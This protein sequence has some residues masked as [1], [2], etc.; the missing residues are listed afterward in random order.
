MFPL[1][2]PGATFHDHHHR[3]PEEM[4]GAMVHMQNLPQEDRLALGLLSGTIRTDHHRSHVR[5]HDHDRHDEGALARKAPVSTDDEALVIVATVIEVGVGA[6]RGAE[7]GTVIKSESVVRH[8]VL[9]NEM[10]QF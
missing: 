10:A 8:V 7:A 5:V 1:F 2:F 9:K 6:P 4:V 3:L